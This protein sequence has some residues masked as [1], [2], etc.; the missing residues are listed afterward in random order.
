[1]PR[2]PKGFKTSAAGTTD[3]AASFEAERL[4]ELS[5]IGTDRSERN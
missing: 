4:T 1:M 2:L 3:A 5:R